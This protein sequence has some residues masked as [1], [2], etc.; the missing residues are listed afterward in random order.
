MST[1]PSMNFDLLPRP[2]GL[3]HRSQITEGPVLKPF[4]YTIC[5]EG[6]SYW[7]CSSDSPGGRFEHRPGKFSTSL[8]IDLKVCK[9]VELRLH[10]T[11]VQVSEMEPN[12]HRLPGSIFGLITCCSQK[13]REPVQY[14]TTTPK[15]TTIVKEL[16]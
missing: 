2:T 16:P 4:S 12:P 13:I 1:G 9:V 14:M 11:V 5:T 7:P 10:S 8:C 3:G 6:L 15:K